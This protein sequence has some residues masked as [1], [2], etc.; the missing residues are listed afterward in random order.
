[1]FLEGREIEEE[2]EP[3]NPGDEDVVRVK[4]WEDWDKTTLRRLW[5]D[6]MDGIRLEWRRDL[7]WLEISVRVVTCWVRVQFEK[8]NSKLQADL[9]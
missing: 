9:Q 1:M 5:D 3:F 8:W 6:A 7:D 2:P 4:Y